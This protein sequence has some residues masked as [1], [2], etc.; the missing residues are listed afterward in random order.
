M[1]DPFPTNLTTGDV[2][3][4]IFSAQILFSCNSLS[5]S[6]ESRGPLG[7]C[8]VGTTTQR[9]GFHPKE[10]R[11]HPQL[12]HS[13]LPECSSVPPTRAR[14]PVVC[15]ACALRQL[16]PLATLRRLSTVTCPQLRDPPAEQ[17]P[18]TE[19]G[20]PPSAVGPCLSGR[21]VWRVGCG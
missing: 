5:L 1:A 10:G 7:I 16:D 2:P 12:T 9:W 14:V 3:P 8:L 21:R 6:S 20:V 15:Q 19:C 18:S 17:V 4:G 11:V 13:S